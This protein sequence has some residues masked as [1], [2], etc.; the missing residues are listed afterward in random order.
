[1]N[2]VMEVKIDKSFQKE[3]KK[4]KDRAILRKIA[5]SIINAQQAGNLNQIKRLKKLKGTTNEYRIRIKDYRLGIIIT[6]SAVEFIRCLHRKDIY[7]YF[8]K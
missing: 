3:V 6:E 1:M 2:F 4:I 7:K 8:P 5:D